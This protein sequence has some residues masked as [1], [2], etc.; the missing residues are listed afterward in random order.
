M[1]VLDLVNM[2]KSYP[3]AS[4]EIPVLMGIDASIAKGESVA[5]VGPS[6]SGKS[7]LL[8]LLAGLDRPTSGS[9]KIAGVEL[10]KL[11][12]EKLTAFRA[13]SLGIVF[14]KFHLMSH[15]TALENVS[16]PLKIAKNGN[17]LDLAEDSLAS[18]G[19]KDRMHHYPHQLS[20]GECQRVAIARA[21][22]ATPDLILADE[23]SGN[24]D[25]ATG[26]EVMN[27]LF[28]LVKKNQS[29]LILVTHNKELALK[30]DRMLTLIDGKLVES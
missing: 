5:I 19:L 16:L 3:H 10:E 21:M 11:S 13:D 24:L 2:K 9:V 4:G 26:E 6:G 15:F 17:Y 27:L 8:S 1:T 20:G 18:V 29:T 12:E 22:V 7:T 30:C 25:S 14:Q 23:P 28:N